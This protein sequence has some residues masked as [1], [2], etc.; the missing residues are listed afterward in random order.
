VDYIIVQAPAT[1]DGTTRQDFTTLA[2]DALGKLGEA[3]APRRLVIDMRQTSRVDSSGLAS[4]VML[5]VRAAERRHSIGLLGAS[6][7]VRFLLLMTRL[8]DRFDLDPQL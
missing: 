8:E 7:E 2:L 4:L 5:Q 1:L 6:E 3:D